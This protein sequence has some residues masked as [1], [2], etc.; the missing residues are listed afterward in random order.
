[1]T[2]AAVPPAVIARLRAAVGAA[3]VVDDPAAMAPY[4][5]D[6][7]RLYRGRAALVLR[8]AATAQV[9]AVVRACAE[10]RVGVVPQGGNTGLVGGSVPG[11]DGGV[12]V[13]SLSRMNRVR[14][15]DARNFAMTVEAG[16]VLK[17]AQD[18]AEAAGLMLPLSLA[19]EGSCQIGGN[20]A[21]NA[22]GTAVLRY[23]NA[24][25][26]VLG[27]EVVLPDG[28]VW[29][30]LGALRK[31]NAG[32]DL[33]QLFLGAEG[34][35]GVITAAV[36]KLFPRPH[37]TETAMVALADPA[38]ATR[39]LARLR[40]SSGDAVTSFE[41]LHRA[42]L[43]LVLAHI[44]GAADPFAEPHWHY[45]LVELA[46]G[47]G[48]GTLRPA[49]EAA[50]GQESEAGGVIDA[51]IADSLDQARRLWAL[52]ETV[53]E[54]QQHAGPSIKHDVS[55]PVSRV[56]EFLERAGR[57]MAREMPEATV[58]A[59][60]HLGDGNIHFNL[61]PRPQTDPARF[62]DRTEAVNRVVHD[63]AAAMGG[64]FSAEHGIGVLKR[65]ELARYKSA[66]E[67]DLMRRLKSALDPDGIMNPGKLL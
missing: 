61:S 51:V 1:M 41:Y 39:L 12:I 27:L 26:L 49:L 38:A 53:S 36:L 2:D 28:R 16:L 50:L 54:A 55:V 47:D 32:Y 65:G 15:V 14:Q 30:G 31:D 29:D 23:G 11:P 22:G 52:R 24:R 20:L 19:S 63:I 13:L 66:V 7:R 58:V 25:D 59:F 6:W 56:P 64:S 33:K 5:T 57:A 3:G 34:T 37:A 43:E 46:S 10:A 17:A 9:A 48:D 42:G 21:S 45:A 18:A 60:G 4:L 44:P 67:L 8:P 62:L 35:L 40:Q